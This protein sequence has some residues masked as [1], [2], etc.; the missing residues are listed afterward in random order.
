MSPPSL[1]FVGNV[2]C[3][4]IFSVDGLPRP[5]SEVMADR[6]AVSAGGVANRAVAAARLGVRSVLNARIGTDELGTAVVGQL[7]AE[8]NLDLSRL[9]V[10]E[11][12]R[13]AVTVSI[14]NHAD[15][16]FITYE[17]PP[18]PQIPVT[19]GAFACCHV[20]AQ[21]E[22]PAWVAELRRAGTIVV[23]GAGWDESGAWSPEFLRR[24]RDLDVLCVNEDEAVNYTR[25]ADPAA[26]A[27]ELA[28]HVP[29]AV[30]TCGKNGVVAAEA[31]DL[32][33]VPALPV[34]VADPTGAGDVF[35][36][37]LMIGLAQKWPLVMGLRLA[38]AAAAISVGRLGGATS[39]PTRAE[40]ADFLAAQDGDWAL[41][42]NW[43]MR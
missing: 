36:A 27:R 28:R 16:S 25:V 19:G 13:T 7:R 3:D 34:T 11:G 38:A 17:E 30:V 31:G 41:I 18:Q 20:S 23:G 8:P 12:M 35:V 37:G 15:R 32:L 5:G 10:T 39:A 40:V 42:R 6:F 1:L 24:I 43:A 33:E 4:L 9:H 22:I 21:A 29:V 2:F 14:A 26:A